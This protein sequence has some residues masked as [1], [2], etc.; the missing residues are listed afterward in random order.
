MRR[1]VYLVVA[2]TLLTLPGT[3]I[4]ADSP[5]FANP[6]FQQQWQ[7]GEAL[8]PNFWGLAITGAVTEQYLYSGTNKTRTVQYFDKGRMELYGGVTNTPNVQVTNGLLATE[9]IKGQVQ[10]A[11]DQFQPMPPPAIPIAG[12]PNNPGPTYATLATTPAG[13]GMLANAPNLGGK[14]ISAGLGPNGETGGSTLPANSGTL[15]TIYD[16]PTQHNVTQA[17]AAYRL[18]AGLATIGYAI[19]EPFAANVKVAGTQRQVI[20]QAFE[21]RVL[22]YTDAN[23]DAFKVE[24]GN[25]GQHYAKWRYPNGG[26][27]IPATLQTVLPTTG[28][29]PGKIVYET[30]SRQSAGEIFVMNPDGSGRMQVAAGTTPLFSPDG[31]RMAYFVAAAPTPDGGPLVQG[32]IRTANIDGS[33][34]K[35]AGQNSANAY[36]TFV[37][38]S[39]DGR[40]LAINGT[41]NGP[42]SILLFDF[43][44]GKSS[45]LT[46]TQGQVSLVYDWAPDG[47]NALWQA[48]ANYSDAKDLYYGDPTRGGDGAVRL[49]N[50]QNRYT[51]NGSAYPGA[52]YTAARFAPDGRSVAVAG[53]TLFFLATPG[54]QSTLAG[55]T[56]GGLGNITSLA[57]SPDGRALAVATSNGASDGTGMI[58]IIDVATG[59]VTPLGTGGLRLDW[60]RQ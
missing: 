34:P 57:W 39:P 18:K 31:M 51:P 13:Q 28:V 26:A 30:T 45:G 36:I 35:D 24:M 47:R 60:T 54:Q 32:I 10:I 40:Y 16:T 56:I 44:T 1:W 27:N 12:D 58:A 22:T 38:W 11:D 2:I 9:M 42:G 14:R 29:Y 49:T 3:P 53:S 23:P 46:F 4:M 5:A 59:H 41:L 52:Y 48:S 8:A 55:K 37:R 19:S 43:M 25:I 21:R 20:I 17:F 6:A 50:G 15:L 7:Q 33:E